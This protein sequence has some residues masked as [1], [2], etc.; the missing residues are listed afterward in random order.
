MVLS[1][2]CPME[3][4]S[5]LS[6]LIIVLVHFY[7]A[8]FGKWLAQKHSIVEHSVNRPHCH[9]HLTPHTMWVIIY[10]SIKLCKYYS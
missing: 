4:G 7:F 3:G 6:L 8:Q 9:S 5:C 1:S 2:V 10:L